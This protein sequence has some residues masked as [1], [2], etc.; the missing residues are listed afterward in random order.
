MN[1]LNALERN[2]KTN[3]VLGRTNQAKKK[4]IVLPKLNTTPSASARIIG[5]FTKNKPGQ[6]FPQL[7]KEKFS[8]KRPPELLTPLFGYQES[9]NRLLAPSPSSPSDSD[10]YPSDDD[11]SEFSEST[12]FSEI[13]SGFLETLNKEVSKRVISGMVLTTKYGGKAQDISEKSLGKKVEKFLGR[14]VPIPVV[15]PR[16]PRPP[17]LLT[18]L[19]SP[20]QQRGNIWCLKQQ[21]LAKVLSASLRA[22]NNKNREGNCRYIRAPLTPIPSVD[23]VFENCGKVDR[24]L[25]AENR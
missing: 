23:W 20:R 8:H 22:V 14:H 19:A 12:E 13:D 11:D 3:S 9:K 17:R 15:S 1:Y 16:T 5:N 6:H 2:K 18:P 21:K 25:S 7:H 24:I 4:A 10:F